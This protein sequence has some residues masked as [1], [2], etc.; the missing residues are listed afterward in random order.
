LRRRGY[1]DSKVRENCE[2][3]ALDVILVET[4][5]DRSA[6]SVLEIDTTTIDPVTCADRIE[7]FARGEI[8]SSFGEI[9]WSRYLEGEE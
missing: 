4:L 3:E 8:P 7:Q 2:A 1:S 5:E 6:E 9:D